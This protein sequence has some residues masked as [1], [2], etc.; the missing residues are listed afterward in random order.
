ML[1]VCSTGSVP[2][3][4]AE[5]FQVATGE[6]RNEKAKSHL[7]AP[8]EMEKE[9]AESSPQTLMPLL[10]AVSPRAFE[11]L[12]VHPL[13]PLCFP[14]GQNLHELFFTQDVA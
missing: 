11:R 1:S 13:P 5:D 6:R 8:G 7:V 9:R 2:G 4:L 10:V 3:A 12:L 14:L